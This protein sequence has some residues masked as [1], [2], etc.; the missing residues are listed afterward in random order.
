M[1]VAPCS[2]Y[3]KHILHVLPI[4]ASLHTEL[5]KFE[6]KP[7]PAQTS[8][9]DILDSGTK[10]KAIEHKMEVIGIDNTHAQNQAL[11]A[12]Q[13]LLDKTN[14][15]G[16]IPGSYERGENIFKFTGYLPMLKFTPDG[17]T[18]KT[19]REK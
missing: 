5:R 8:I 13:K 10:E 11:F 12:I 6:E 15:Q 18:G 3:P 2:Y 7:I 17:Y 4:K 19:I 1:P 14:Y 16:N 9:F